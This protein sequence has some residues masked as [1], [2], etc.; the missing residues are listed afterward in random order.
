MIRVLSWL[1]AQPNGRTKYSAEHVNI[2]ADSVDRHLSMDHELAIVT[3]M[4]DGID[5]RIRI[6]EPPRLFEDVRIPTWDDHHGKQL[7]QCHRRLAMFAP[8]A[9]ETFGERFVSMDL[10][11]IIAEPLD[12][13]FD[14]E[15]D[16]VMYRG[17]TGARPY[18]GSMVMMTAGARPRV[19][20]E[21]TPERAAEAGRK[22]VGSDQAWISYM[23]GW[24]E[25]TWGPEDGVVWWGSSKNYAAP[26]WRLMFFPGTP[27]P[28]EIADDP[29][30]TMHYRRNDEWDDIPCREIA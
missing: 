4:P 1:W 20:T 5:P 21:F 8:N 7:P 6:I 16:F 13:L 11:C 10:D 27:K 3:D 29:W 2:W 26:E 24:G 22:Y 19:Y 28:W 14:R 17:T 18:N 25:A 30:I 12:S 15:E 23:L 9:A